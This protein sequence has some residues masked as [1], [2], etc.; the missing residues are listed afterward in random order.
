[1]RPNGNRQRPI[2][3]ANPLPSSTLDVHRIL[4]DVRRLRLWVDDALRLAQ[5]SEDTEAVTDRLNEARRERIRQGRNNV[6]LRVDAS[7][8]A[9]IAGVALG[10]EWTSEVDLRS[11]EQAIAATNHSLAVDG[12][13][14]ARA[15][16]QLVLPVVANLGGIA[17]FSPAYSTS[18]S[19]STPD[20]AGNCAAQ[21]G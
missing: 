2:S 15:R 3:R 19:G 1:M 8:V 12:I 10:A 7:R 11:I 18:P 4:L 14:N 9:G 17:P 13:S 5:A 6:P 20:P 21:S 16:A